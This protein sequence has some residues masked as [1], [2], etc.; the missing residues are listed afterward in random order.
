MHWLQQTLCFQTKF[1]WESFNIHTTYAVLL[2]NNC[3]HQL[4]E[5]IWQGTA[6]RLILLA[7]CLKKAAKLSFPH[8]EIQF[9]LLCLPNWVE[10]F[11]HFT[12]TGPHVKYPTVPYT[13]PISQGPAQQSR[14]S[15]PAWNHP[16]GALWQLAEILQQLGD[17]GWC[18]PCCQE[19]NAFTWAHLSAPL[20]AGGHTWLFQLQN[21]LNSHLHPGALQCSLPGYPTLLPDWFWHT[22]WCLLPSKGQP[23]QTQGNPTKYKLGKPTGTAWVPVK[24]PGLDLQQSKHHIN[25][26]NT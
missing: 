8:I 7:L 11:G 24:S 10:I 25:Q 5:V 14:Q 21:P 3:F 13:L 26:R 22:E 2:F 4:M 12:V 18:S 16:V 15:S 20:L 19:S 9:I 6:A 1:I 17:P 23:L